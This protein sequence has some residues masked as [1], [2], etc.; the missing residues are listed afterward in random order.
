[1]ADVVTHTEGNISRDDLVSLYWRSG[2]WELGT[3]KMEN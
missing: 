1:M 2:V 3:L